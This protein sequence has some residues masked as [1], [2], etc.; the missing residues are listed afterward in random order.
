MEPQDY[1]KKH[2]EEGKKNKKSQLPDVGS[3]NPI[4]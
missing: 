2:T 3:Y 1:R 4:P